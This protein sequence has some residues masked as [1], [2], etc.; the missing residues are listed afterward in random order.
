MSKHP[1]TI[2]LDQTLYKAV[3][4]EAHNAGLSFSAVVHLL[5]QAF[6]Q[7]TVQIGVTQYP[8]EYLKKL[9]KESKELSRLYRKG[10]MKGYASSKELFDDILER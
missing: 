7:G 1:T 8:Q 2:R 4:K 5:L 6:T 9:E 10:K 3:L